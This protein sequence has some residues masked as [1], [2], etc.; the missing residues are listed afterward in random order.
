MKE[1]NA[2]D[3]IEGV[4]CL[5][6]S[7]QDNELPE[8]NSSQ[9]ATPLL[10]RRE[11][12]AEATLIGGLVAGGILPTEADAASTPPD[13]AASMNE[14]PI[15]LHINGVD[16]SMVVE[17]RV[18]LLDALRERAGLTGAKKGCDH[19]QCGACT[20][21]VGGRR[22]NSCMTLAVMHQGQPITTIEGLAE[23]EKLHPMQAAFLAYDGFQ[24]GLCTPGQILSAVS[25]VQE[26]HAHSEAEIQ[27]AMSGNLC[28]CGAYNNIVAA[29]RKVLEDK[30]NAAL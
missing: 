16:V 11:L 25:L 27:E 15:S 23:G 3:G 22:I 8:R 17:P 12:L 7:S 5:S 29:I 26:G 9:P 19:G 2:H 28:R 18:T 20:V 4:Q 1:Q 21:H 30:K 14:I 24:C 10:S 13:V 6:R